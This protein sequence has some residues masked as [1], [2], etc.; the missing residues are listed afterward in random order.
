MTTAPEGPA[1]HLLVLATQCRSQYR[2]DA[3]PQAAAEL[4]DALLDPARGGCVPALPDG[5][6]LLGGDD[7]VDYDNARLAL[8]SAMERAGQAGAT[9]VLALLGHGFTP[10]DVS[11]LYFMT[12]DSTERRDNALNVQD[13]LAGAVESTGTGGVVA[14]LDTCNAAS[15]VL[16]VEDLVAGP[17][18]GRGG[19]S[20]LTA[21]GAHQPA[22]DMRFS[23]ELARLLTDGQSGGPRELHAEQLVVGLRPRLPGQ[24][25]VAWGY[26]GA[27]PERLWIAHN[28]R[29]APG[30]YAQGLTPAAEGR[31]GRSPSDVARGP[32]PFPTDGSYRGLR[33]KYLQWAGHAWSYIDLGGLGVDAG[34]ADQQEAERLRRLDLGKM[35][36]SLQA[37]PRSLADRRRT[38]LL[39]RLNEQESRRSWGLPRPRRDVRPSGV[40]ASAEADPQG[41]I[42]LEE[43]FARHKI[44]VVL[45]PPG[46]GKSVLCQWLARTIADE[47]LEILRRPRDVP[48]PGRVRLPLRIR[49]ADYARYYDEEFTRGEPPGS[50][51]E[52]LAATADQSLIDRLTATRYVAQRM[53]ERALAEGE[54]VILIDG[55]DE[56]VEHRE[57]VLAVL[58][59]TVRAHAAAGR[60][61]AQVVITSRTAG[62]DEVYLPLDDA[63]HYLIR[64]MTGKQVT[65]YC[66]S[67]FDH[68]QQPQL[69]ALMLHQ[70]AMSDRAVQ[71][72][73]AT[74]IL[75]T[76]MCMYMYVHGNLPADQAQLYRELVLDTGY[77]WRAIADSTRGSA[78][79]GL[80]AT[81]AE[82][83]AVMAKIA[84]RIH[85]RHPDGRIGEN[86]LL[87]AL[88]EALFG[89]G[90]LTR[91]SRTSEALSLID[92]IRGKVGILAEE[93]PRRFGF[94]HQ[95]FRE[96]LVGHDLLDAAMA[97]GGRDEPPAAVAVRLAGH[98]R[99]NER[100]ADH[101]WRVPVLLAIDSCTP[102]V[103]AAVIAQAAEGDAWELEEWADLLLPADQ[104][105]TAAVR[106]AD[107]IRALLTLFARFWVLAP[108][109]AEVLDEYD[110]RLAVLRGR[111][112]RGLF[113]TVALSL[114]EQD[115]A[116][117]GPLSALYERRQ[118]LTREVLT[119]FA[120][121]TR[122][123]TGE[124]GWPVHRALRR[125]AAGTPARSV[126]ILARFETPQDDDLS[127]GAVFARRLA[128]L[129]P[130]PWQR[131]RL[132]VSEETA[133]E[134]PSG[135]LPVR[136]LLTARPDRF[137]LCLAD[138]GAARV[139][140]VLFGGL[141]HH[142]TLTWSA[143]YDDF[144]RLLN[145]P[146]SARESAIE[147]R[148]AEL[149]PRFGTTD[150]VYSIAVMLD[151]VGTK[152]S[153]R[154]KPPAQIEVRWLSRRCDPALTSAIRGWVLATPGDPAALRRVLE[155]TAGAGPAPVPEVSATARTEAELGLLVLD[156][157]PMTDGAD[158]LR[159]VEGALEAT[160]DAFLR[161]AH[162]LVRAVWD[163][164]VPE[165]ERPALHR[166]LLHAAFLAAGRPVDLATG[167][168]L[169]SQTAS[170]LHADALACRAL[171]G[172]WYEH[173][174]TDLNGLRGDR[175]LCAL[176]WFTTLPYFQVRREGNLLEQPG[177]PAL[178]L[179]PTAATGGELGT[180]I[181]ALGAV[182]GWFA[183]TAPWLGQV[184]VT[185]IL[186]SPRRPGRAAPVPADLP[187][188]CR[189]LLL[190]SDAQPDAD[191]LA[192]L[193]EPQAELPGTDSCARA[194]LLIALADRLPADRR[195]AHHRAALALL[196][197]ARDEAR[198]AEALYRCRDHLCDDAEVRAGFDR[199]VAGLDSPVLRADAAGD[200]VGCA[201]A[202]ALRLADGLSGQPQRVALLTVPRLLAERERLSRG[203]GP[204]PD[205]GLP[206]PP[207]RAGGHRMD[208]RGAN[209]PVHGWSRPLDR[210]LLDRLA[211]L[212][213]GPDGEEAAAYQLSLV[214]SVDADVVPGLNELLALPSAAGK[215]WADTVRDL[216]ALHAALP[217]EG[218]PDLLA[219]ADLIMRADAGVVARARLELLGAYTYGGRATRHHLLSQ[220]G[221]D[222]WWRLAR[223]AVAE[224]DM[225]RRGLL[226]TALYQWDVDDAEAVRDALRRAAAEE[227]GWDAWAHMLSGGSIWQPGPQ[228]VLVEWLDSGQPLPLPALRAVVETAAC[229][230]SSGSTVAVADEL[231]EAVARACVRDRLP[232]LT[233]SGLPGGTYRFGAAKPVVEACHAALES[234]AAGSADLVQV[235]RGLLRDSAVPLCTAQEGPDRETL[236]RYSDLIWRLTYARA[237][238]TAEWIPEELDTPRAIALLWRW[239][240]TMAAEDR[241][242]D[243]RPI[244]EAVTSALLNLLVVLSDDDPTA[245]QLHL[246][247]EEAQPVLSVAA[248]NKADESMMSALLLMSRLRYVHLDP[249]GGGP[250]LVEVLEVSMRGSSR[251]CEAAFVFVQHVQRVQGGSLVNALLDRLGGC[252]NELVAHGLTGLAAA[253][254]RSPGCTSAESLR[255]RRILRALGGTPRR[256]VQVAGNGNAQDDPVALAL[257]PDRRTEFRRLLRSAPAGDDLGRYLDFGDTA[258]PGG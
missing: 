207:G 24:L 171:G 8:G 159:A 123:D 228:A 222:T 40:L 81:P 7:E 180:P 177:A 246:A 141:D 215:R 200:L 103:K 183:R 140:C 146:N 244:D 94:I 258:S 144:A 251:L 18:R 130:V 129:G 4:R 34:A 54:A 71:V 181:E 118:W 151:T 243:A 77:R 240:R 136:D 88:E 154:G 174:D 182:V 173:E 110:H 113:D 15:G 14:L 87:E 139:L 206:V 145:L 224:P 169:G 61:A 223:A 79:E 67:F 1:R 167:A 241:L 36:V 175:L 84:R 195:P 92:L 38:E 30:T 216:L 122:A 6:A 116:L 43:A 11:K 186:T 245:F 23:R 198:L 106:E 31:A 193:A 208:R 148:A 179:T 152:V 100:L 90:R 134:V 205:A 82:F 55:L 125:A 3:L 41:A 99:E 95:T 58:T 194:L 19:L 184:L 233:L 187:A 161:E 45:G 114:M 64:P 75:L 237:E 172:A 226:L 203:G 239:L 230:I 142:D 128:E 121:L 46:S 176:G 96:Y 111:A 247:P 133:E 253:C 170:V 9:L 68:L 26:G 143:E 149:V 242:G 178:W 53:F 98:I 16:S 255:I 213:G 160:A 115:D 199:L 102:Q 33:L 86:A 83:L 132:R 37:D 21:T 158:S 238:A 109:E 221:V 166:F 168:G 13:L 76:S 60:A 59:E 119:V 153:T 124:W 42:A 189:A 51:A 235:A 234:T 147:R 127:A 108:A 191:V 204:Y 220:R 73:A 164:D 85:E 57:D 63:A 101:R 227:G 80:L 44:L 104:E 47:S 214:T 48:P 250:G 225:M 163:G 91:E 17:R 165:R 66:E 137:G 74:P 210:Q 254:Y 62:Y 117:V 78:L 12:A 72:L 32:V 20:V 39:R 25:P 50:L 5:R 131:Q 197:T 2:L 211:A 49:A 22:Y 218:P 217:L 93:S 28:V 188:R 155:S 162:H 97:G 105:G 56:L 185:E 248:V 157:R 256:L 202:L 69:A 138:D 70:L 10:G 190:D 257:G 120:R 232:E 201:Q 231:V 229:Q 209:G 112:G 196:A 192:E 236:S 252:R 29:P 249:P 89:L 219:L 156:G 126:E 107:E 150:V 35:Y 135:L 212:V 65:V 52:F 27:R